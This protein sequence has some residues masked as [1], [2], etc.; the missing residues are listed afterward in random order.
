M[1]APVTGVAERAPATV[2]QRYGSGEHA[3]FGDARKEMQALI[4]G[5]SVDY[6]GKPGER[7]DQI[8]RKFGVTVEALKK[9]NSAKLRRWD[10]FDG[11]GRKIV[12]FNAGE[13]IVILPVLNAEIEAALKSSSGTSLTIN[14]VTVD[15]GV[16]IAM[17]DFFESPE[18]MA[19]ASKVELKRLAT[20]ITRERSGGKVSTDEWQAATSG[21]YLKLAERNEA[22]FAPSDTSL[23]PASGKGTANHKTEW[24]KH[25]T[26]ALGFSQKGNKDKA[27]RTN[28]FGDHF[29]TDAFAGGHLINKR[30]VMQLFQSKLVNARGE[31][32]GDAT[33]FF[34]DVSKSSFKG[35]VKSTFSN[36]E[37]VE[38]KGGFF[39]PNINSESR[40]SKLLQGINEKEPDVLSNAIAK[41]AHDALNTFS[42]GVPVQN[43]VGDS[44][45][46]SG[47]GTLNSK[48]RDIARKAVAQSLL[49][50]LGV[51]KAKVL[52]PIASLLKKVWD[53]VPRPIKK[54]TK[55]VSEEVR[56]GTDPTNARLVA[57]VSD[58]IKKNYKKILDELVKKKFLKKK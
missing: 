39:R 33:K 58:L 49:N 1:V 40:F 11:S 14:G 48:S 23:A 2:I 54:G 50:V 13:K 18:L 32:T 20:L 44:W 29:L 6:T 24:K 17:G 9:A 8:A 51:F 4:D 15:Y 38:Y 45:N 30:D 19:Q 37:T 53:F 47:D 3:Q 5:E 25:H 41:A 16:G 57:A 52:P 28:A 27:L 35:K 26:S 55:I 10:A 7:L 42:G 22:H 21:R 12:G 36:Y 43:K 31:L 46:L 34:D 56:S